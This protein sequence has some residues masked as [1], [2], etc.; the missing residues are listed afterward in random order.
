MESIINFYNHNKQIVSQVPTEPPGHREWCTENETLWR[1]QN[2]LSTLQHHSAD[3]SRVAVIDKETRWMTLPHR[4]LPTPKAQRT[5]EKCVAPRTCRF[6]LALL[7]RWHA[8][9]LSFACLHH[10]QTVC[11]KQSKEADTRLTVI[12]TQFMLLRLTPSQDAEGGATQKDT[13]VV[14]E[15]ANFYLRGRRF[16]GEAANLHL[17]DGRGGISESTVDP[18]VSAQRYCVILCTLVRR[19]PSY[20]I[21]EDSE[22]NTRLLL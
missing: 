14:G 10:A 7:Q 1:E 20:V 19:D 16:F 17:R 18:I 13:W 11:N 15:A 4:S 3:A 6:C 12:C 21:L 2:D 9:L 5:N 22:M 8:T